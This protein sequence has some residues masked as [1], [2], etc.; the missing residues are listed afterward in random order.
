MN[1]VGVALLLIFVLHLIDKHNRW[2][3]A[4]KLTVGMVVLGILGVSGFFGWQKYE[5]YQE[6][7]IANFAAI[8]RAQTGTAYDDLNDDDLTKKVL[9]KYGSMGKAESAAKAARQAQVS[10]CV[11]RLEQ[12]PVP[13][14]APVADVPGNIQTTC[15]ANPEATT[16]LYISTD[17]PLTPQQ[18][19]YTVADIDRSTKPKPKL[20]TG[21]QQQIDWSKYAT[22][23]NCEVVACSDW[24]VVT[25][26]YGSRI[27]SR[28][29]FDT[30]LSSRVSCGN[31][32]VLKKGDRAQILS[33]KVRAPDG[34]DIY[35]AKFQQWRGWVSASDLSPEKG[36][37]VPLAD[38]LN[39]D[40]PPG[41]VREQD[42]FAKLGG[43]A[44]SPLPCVKSSLENE[45]AK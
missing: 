18:G 44:L 5:A 31:I 26:E 25:A 29:C 4:L 27:E 38:R 32:A 2:R 34:S 1:F 36:E 8:I 3:Q 6:E 28:N 22:P 24:A 33:D 10:A 30:E 45:K 37:E 42:P 20:K 13:K 16:Y 21:S 43:K 11:S 9:A 40:C 12:S 14:D 35:E 17:A 19:Q 41:E 39:A 7:K 23:P 15:D